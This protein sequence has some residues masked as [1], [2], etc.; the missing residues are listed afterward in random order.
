MQ[1]HGA[2]SRR[3]LWSLAGANLPGGIRAAAPFSDVSRFVFVPSAERSIVSA[4][5]GDRNEIVGDLPLG[6][7]PRQVLLSRTEAKLIATDGTS[8]G[9]ATFDLSKS[10]LSRVPLPHVV[11]RIVLGTSGWL[12]AAAGS[13]GGSIT[14]FDIRRGITMGRID[15][16]PKL[17]DFLFVDQ[18]AFLFVAAEGWS[19]I[20]VIDVNTARLTR[21]IGPFGSGGQ[22]VVALARTPNGRSVL[23]LPAGDNPPSIIDVESGDVVGELG[24]VAAADGVVP[25][26]TGAFLIVP[27]NK[28]ARLRIYREGQ[29]AWATSLPAQPGMG[30]V[31]SAWLDSVA[32]VSCAARRQLL[33]YDLD[34]LRPAGSIDLQ[35]IPGQGGVTPDSRTLYVPLTAPSALAVID[36]QTRKV[37]TTV[38]LESAPLA[39]VV[40]GGWGL[41]H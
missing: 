15:G 33:V 11:D 32:F 36:S 4:I 26:G 23:V 28:E 40:P 18:D 17:R 39:A 27:D 22:G 25:S 13:K 35:G 1:R 29:S 8:A 16:L 24:A 3:S 14:L 20:A 12:V 19:G 41:C 21:R 37:V 6:V 30:P 38:P 9:F 2:A 31:Y 34:K 10:E 5:D 7:V